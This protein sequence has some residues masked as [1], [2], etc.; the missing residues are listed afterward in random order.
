MIVAVRLPER[1]HDFLLWFNRLES[2][3]EVDE[4]LDPVRPVETQSPGNQSSPVMPDNKHLLRIIW[5]NGVEEL[6]E[7]ADQVEQGELGRVVDRGAGGVAVALKS[8]ATAR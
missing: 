8:G 4:G 6:N 2:N 3:A 7:V 1:G 5:G